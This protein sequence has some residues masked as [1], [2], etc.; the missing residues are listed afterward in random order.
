M[1]EKYK[2]KLSEYLAGTENIF[3]HNKGRVSLY[4]ILKSMNIGQNDE[5]ILPAYTCVVVA[6]AII[7]LKAKPIY[8]DIS[9]ETYNMNI[10]LLEKA[11]SDKTKAVICQNT[12]GL[13][14]NIEEIISISK[15]K[16][17][18]TIEDCTHGFGGTYNGKAN[19]TY[20]DAAFY[21]TQWNKPFSTGIGGFAIINNEN[22]LPAMSELEKEKISLSKKTQ[23]GLK[24]QYFAKKYFIND[25]TYWF[26]LK[27]YRWLSKKNIVTGSSAGEEISSTRMPENFFSDLSKA[28]IKEGFKNIN[29]LPENLLLR[30]K[31]AKIYTDF[32]K[33]NNKKYVSE[34]YF[35]N[36]SFLKY[37]MLVND[38][39]S[40]F[41]LA[42]KN[43]IPFGDWFISPLHPAEDNFEKWL[44]DEAEFPIAMETS[45]KVVN[46]PTDTKNISKIIKYLQKNI[47]FIE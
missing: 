2:I 3:F 34:K 12:Y 37:P 23:F 6:N 43:K 15:N 44:F 30:K 33:E 7:Y 26:L 11:I 27:I 16:N 42:E 4:A 45:K 32:L 21:S 39:K 28:Q 5:V 47:N 31:N 40:F 46:I 35:D 17:L 38:R 1:I 14:S 20:C 24:L 25:T 18:Y 29:K 22:L 9:E 36:H 10:E 41:I 8:V 19:G 13:S